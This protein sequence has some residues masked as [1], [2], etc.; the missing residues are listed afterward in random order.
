[1]GLASSVT[2]SVAVSALCNV[3]L[4]VTLIVQ[5]L[6]GA[7]VPLLRQVVATAKSAAFAPVIATALA[8][9]CSV[10][11][12]PLVNVI[13]SAALVWFRTWLPKASGFGD[14]AACGKTPVPVRLTTCVVGLA[15]SA[16]VIV[17]ARAPSCDG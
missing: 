12:P 9:R 10:S 14:S 8:A 6:F 5:V 13:V 7:T 2:V 4:T 3:G 17:A 11:V 16:N 1:V 15:S